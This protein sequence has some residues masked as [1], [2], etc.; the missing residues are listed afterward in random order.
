[1][2]PRPGWCLHQPP[3]STLALGLPSPRRLARVTCTGAR[4]PAA[5]RHGAGGAGCGGHLCVVAWEKGAFEMGRSGVAWTFREEQQAQ[6]AQRGHSP[7]AAGRAGLW[8][9]GMR[10]ALAQRWCLCATRSMLESLK[11]GDACA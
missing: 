9:G 8:D 6:Q 5:P 3:A 1:M 7:E 11:T 10:W 4:Q 2:W